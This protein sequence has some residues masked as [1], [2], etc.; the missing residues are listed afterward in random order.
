MVQS[1]NVGNNSNSNVSGPQ[2][3]VPDSNYS[4][5]S[6]EDS[7]DGNEA[8]TSHYGDQY[9]DGNL[10][11]KVGSQNDVGNSEIGDDEWASMMNEDVSSDEPSAEDL[12]QEIE[13]LMKKIQESDLPWDQKKACIASLI[14]A[15]SSA[16]LGKTEDATA[17]YQDA[18]DNFDSVQQEAKD[19]KEEK[20]AEIKTTIEGLNKQLESS[21]LSSEKK[22]KLRGQIEAI[23]RK[24]N[25]PGFDL[26]TLD[27]DIKDVQ[28]E[29]KKAELKKLFVG[30]SAKVPLDSPEGKLTTEFISRVDKALDTDDWGPVKDM[31]RQLNSGD[32]KG[33]LADK[34]SPWRSDNLNG[35]H[36]ISQFMGVVLQNVAGMDE[37]KFETVL[38]LI[39]KDIRQTMMNA[40]KADRGKSA[41]GSGTRL[42]QF[43]ED[44]DDKITYQ[45]YGSSDACADRL[46]KSLK[47]DD[48]SLDSDTVAPTPVPPASQDAA[49]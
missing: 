33:D 34:D 25:I 17:L 42:D 5:D 14:K 1:N 31:L 20:S 15:R 23:Q 46:D 9:Q 21:G 32:L 47:E 3:K 12:H 11:F 37:G 10:S 19:A 6:Y 22:Q 30:L 40:V 26:S 38:D 16:E 43:I 35:G 27:S 13:T 44:N 41:W 7:L 28:M 18:Q 49:A 48:I 36:V 4:E 29:L 2:G 8:S 45:Y 39:P 24:M